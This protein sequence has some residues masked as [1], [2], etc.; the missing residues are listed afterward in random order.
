M[1]DRT[2]SVAPDVE[3]IRVDK[4][5]GQH[6]ALDNLS[7]EVQQS[8]FVAVLGPTGCGKSTALRII[9]GLEFPD[10]GMVRLQGQDAS[11]LPPNR[12]ATSTVFQHFALFPN[13]SVAD[14]IAYGLK[15]RKLSKD[16]IRRRVGDAL[17]L[18]RLTG[19]GRKRIQ[20]L[21][22]GEQQRVAVARALV[23]RPRILLLDEPLSA[24]DQALRT[25][26]QVELRQLQQELNIA[27]VLVTH[28]Q[29]EALS[30]ADRVAVMSKGAVVQTGVCD[31]VYRRPVNRFVAK[32]LGEANLFELVNV[33]HDQG[34]TIGE[35][36]DG[37]V[38]L[39]GVEPGSG[40]VTICIRPESII[41]GPR[42]ELLPNRFSATIE[43]EIF[44]GYVR[45]LILRT[46]SG[47]RIISTLLATEQV[48]ERGEKVTIG[49]DPEAATVL[50]EATA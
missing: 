24:I 21:S 31:D 46:P 17:D 22:G 10:S 33:H 35:H 37:P 19:Y 16:E 47:M 36:P 34:V 18:V 43:D 41:C 38:R 29:Q 32:F 44:R 28:D 11:N 23:T 12:R 26:M 20:G 6:R 2:T 7:L 25:A 39:A 42:A 49:W 40:A 13:M 27:F 50:E 5:F 14:N 48:G 8:E 3:L 45:S 15:V 30:L 9:A 1:A 4:R